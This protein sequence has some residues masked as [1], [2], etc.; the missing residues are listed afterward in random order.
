DLIIGNDLVR[1]VDVQQISAV[2]QCCSD[3][4]GLSNIFAL[5]CGDHSE[6]SLSCARIL[7]GDSDELDAKSEDK[8]SSAYRQSRPGGAISL[9][10][11]RT[12]FDA[13]TSPGV[14]L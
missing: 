8:T 1:V 13:H 11:R 7:A 3:D 6:V 9:N 5:S 2:G 12:R 14:A 4:A 10:L